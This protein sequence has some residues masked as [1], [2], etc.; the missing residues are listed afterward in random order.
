MSKEYKNNRSR[1]AER[2]KSEPVQ[3]PIQEVRP[4]ADQPVPSKATAKVKR[5]ESET[6]INFWADE[7]LGERL[8]IHAVKSKKTIKQI[9][10]EA[11]EKY[12][13]PA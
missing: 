8:R 13:P 7:E 5:A 3:T 11:L 6:H 10:V 9:C 1:L 2:L 12:L 4:I